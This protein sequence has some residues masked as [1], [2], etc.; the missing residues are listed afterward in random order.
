MA[1]QVM[2]RKRKSSTVMRMLAA[3]TEEFGGAVVHGNFVALPTP[4]EYREQIAIKYIIQI[5][6]VN[7]GIA[8]CWMVLTSTQL[9]YREIV[10]DRPDAEK[11]GWPETPERW[12]FAAVCFQMVL[13]SLLIPCIHR[14]LRKLIILI[15]VLQFF[16]AIAALGTFAYDAPAAGTVCDRIMMYTGT[17]WRPQYYLTV[18]YDLLNAFSLFNLIVLLVAYVVRYDKFLLLYFRGKVCLP[19]ETPAA[20]GTYACE[21]CGMLVRIE[22]ADAHN[23]LFCPKPVSCKYC[24]LRILYC[25]V[26]PELG[27]TNSLPT[28]DA[29]AANPFDVSARRSTMA[30]SPM[31][32]IQTEPLEHSEDAT[33]EQRELLKQAL[34]AHQRVCLARPRSQQDT[35]S[36]GSASERDR[37]MMDFSDVPTAHSPQQGSV[38]VPS[39]PPLEDSEDW[40]ARK[41][42]FVSQL[43]VRRL[44]W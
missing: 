14:A 6:Y 42:E 37:L 33:A 23:D 36:R 29:S 11:L 38:E 2:E 35:L 10:Q 1:T 22:D 30:P 4:D 27:H 25:E 17:C 43:R 16:V 18:I 40:A 7:M 39:Q 28:E 26:A 12:R 19:E 44:Q 41:V 24:N 20:V 21:M 8:L 3:S 5:V 31:P 13:S 15:V 9:Q 32:Q 34:Q